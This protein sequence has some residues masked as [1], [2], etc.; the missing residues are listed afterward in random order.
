[1]KIYSSR[2]RIQ[3]LLSHYKNVWGFSQLAVEES[4]LVL[5]LQC[6]VT[7]PYYTLEDF[8]QI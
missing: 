3:P 4:I 5:K 8:S 7:T 2:E 1:M 6:F